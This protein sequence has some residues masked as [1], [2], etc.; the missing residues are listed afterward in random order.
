MSLCGKKTKTKMD[1]LKNKFKAYFNPKTEIPN[2][3]SYYGCWNGLVDTNVA[4]ILAGAGFDWVLIDGEHAPFDLRTIQAQLQAMGQFD[5]PILVRS[6]HGDAHLI[7]QLLDIGV[8]SLLVPMVETA[9]Q[10][11]DLYKAMQYPPKGIRGVGTGLARAAQWN[12]VNNY[13]KTAG[14]EMCL[15]VQVESVKG[16]EN[17]E[18]IANTEG[19]DGVF[20]GP[21]DLAASMGFL[22]QADRIEVKTVVENALRTIR[23]AGK[24]AGVMVIGNK[25]LADHYADCG[26]NMIAIAIDTLLL[27]NA[28]KQAALT[29]TQA[30]ENQSNTKY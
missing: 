23:K 1:I 4:E 29:Y 8:Q 6:P 25:S 13:F 26:A 11:A 21:S 22:G 5:T 10:A 19:V 14:D 3:T 15:I 28:S 17:L 20:I 27:A 30:I 12:R 18:S 7:K 24:I 2:P 16:I 9:E